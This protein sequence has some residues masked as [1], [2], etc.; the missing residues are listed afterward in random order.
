MKAE[1]LRD[2]KHLRR[3]FADYSVFT[4]RRRQ[5]FGSVQ[6]LHAMGIQNFLIYPA[7]L[8][9]S[10]GSSQQSFELKKLRNSWPKLVMVRHR[11]LTFYGPP[12]PTE[13]MDE[14]SEPLKVPGVSERSVHKVHPPSVSDDWNRVMNI[15]TYIY[16]FFFFFCAVKRF[17]VY[18]VC[19]CRH[20]RLIFTYC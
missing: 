7:V 14:E 4:S 1:P 15:H 6:E 16:I 19:S 5:A 12:L 2:Q 3:F 17:D 11:K 13:S 20:I 18:I 8:R 9:V 10:S